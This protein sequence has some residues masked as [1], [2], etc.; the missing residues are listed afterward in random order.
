M[1]P[2]WDDIM[3]R[4]V[5]LGYRLSPASGAPH[6]WPVAEPYIE[7]VI[8][9]DGTVREVDLEASDTPEHH[10]HAVETVV[11]DLERLAPS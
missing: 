3:R 8:G 5:A 4:A 7:L 11:A 9:A 2:S 1:I 6:G 10:R